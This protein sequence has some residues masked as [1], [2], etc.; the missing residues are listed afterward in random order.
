[1]LADVAD[2]VARSHDLQQTLGN[3]VELVV[4]KLGADVCSIYLTDPSLEHLTLWATRGL[5]PEAVGRVRL[6][7]GEGLVGLAARERKPIAVERA[8]D[9]PRF[10][11]FPGTGEERFQSL[12]ATPLL[13]RGMPIGVLVVQ[14]ERPRQFDAQDIDLLQTCAQLIA[15][16]VMNAR[17]LDLVA[18]T[19]EERSKVVAKLAHSGL[20]LRLAEQAAPPSVELH[21]SPTS[22]GIAI[23]PL[24]RLED[25][26]DL[27][28][29]DYSPNPDEV[30]EKRDLQRAISEARSELDDVCDEVAE[31]FGPEFAA[32]FNTHIQILEDKGFTGR[33]ERAVEDTGNAL[34]ALRDVLDDYR[35]TF[36]AIEDP[37]FRERGSDIEDVGRRVMARLLGVRHHNVPLQAGSIVVA[38]EI[39]PAH[40]ALL[41]TEKIAALVAEHGGATSHGAIF[42]RSLEIPAVTGVTGIL[43]ATRPGE[44]AIVDGASGRVYLR[45]DAALRAE[46]ERAQQR[47]E[48]AVEHLDTLKDRPAETRDGRRIQ[49]TANV[50]L[51]N[52]LRLIEQ[53]G[54]EGVGLFRTELLAIAH[55]GFPEEEEQERLY[56]RVAK[57]IAPRPVTIRTLDLGGDKAVPLAGV[58]EE[59]NPQLGWRSTRLMLSHEGPFRAQLRAIL[60]AT[61]RRNVRVLLPLI[62]S[63]E[64]LRLARALLESAKEELCNRGVPFD[65][66]VALGIMI[67]VPSAALIA[68][69]LARECDF[70]SIGTNDL[71][72]YTLAVDRGN[73]RVAHLYDP[74]HPAVL[75]LIDRS[76]RAAARAGIPVSLCGEMASNPLA[77]PL[78]VGLG[79]G[80]LSGTPSSVP[81]V[82]EIVR[83]LDAGAAAEA[84]RSALDAATVE[85][86]HAIAAACLREA[87]LLD[88]PDVGNWL[89]GVLGE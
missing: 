69:A 70:F 85:D 58:T 5:A 35:Q 14:T 55:R 3:V 59:E 32:V 17:L 23:G 37:Y 89:R 1:M 38:K 18:R 25:P 61:T 31:R 9:D 12:L 57:A 71:T 7:F 77:V 28:R 2:V 36:E 78:L 6:A 24:Y 54:A 52:D 81:V 86:S 4:K 76:V 51:L 72:Q 63:V 49:L 64:E 83:A 21:G 79:I 16:V 33:I 87:G 47:Y 44:L 82:K 68:D 11:F 56:E 75:A 45:P 30:Q 8:Q 48:V 46:Y 84:A 15:P 26:V 43:E 29:V 88:H 22:P 80:E 10:R 73:E 19:E 67:E 62:G 13:V 40:F 27:A 65:R 39:L 34:Q 74:L 66:D 60:R 42:A 50:G 53:H 20:G 41:E